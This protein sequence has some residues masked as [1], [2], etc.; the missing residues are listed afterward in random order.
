[1]KHLNFL[2]WGDGGNT[3]TVRPNN[4]LVGNPLI[5]L[6]ADGG[7][8]TFSHTIRPDQARALAQDLLAI[9]NEVECAANVA[10]MLKEAEE[11]AA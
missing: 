7:S 5:T 10:Q 11:V 6:Y 9:A 8:L 4:A 3:L 1:M 2:D